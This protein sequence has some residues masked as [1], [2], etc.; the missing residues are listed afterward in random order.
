MF[1]FQIGRSESKFIENIVDAI[2]GHV[3][4]AKYPVHEEKSPKQNVVELLGVGKMHYGCKHYRSRC[5]IRTPCCNKIYSCRYCH[6]EATSNHELIRYEVQ[7]VICSIC[8]KE[9]PAAQVCTNCGVCMG[10]YYCNIC[11]LYDDDTT[12]QQFH[13]HQCGICR[14]GGREN[15]S[16][17]KKCGGCLENFLR[18]NHTCVNLRQDCPICD[19]FLFESMKEFKPM[20]CGHIIHVECYD[21]MVKCG[22]TICPVCS[23]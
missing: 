17:C 1:S 18:D 3:N 2:S 7:Q 16:H 15:Y 9:Q 14:L 10:E 5:K 13:C 20:N 12:K 22:I 21:K 11:K 23:K 19:E 4:K 8:D 6:N